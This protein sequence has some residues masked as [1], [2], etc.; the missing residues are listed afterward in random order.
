M[1]RKFVRQLRPT[2]EKYVAPIIKIQSLKESSNAERDAVIKSVEGGNIAEAVYES[3]AFIVA[4]TSGTKTL[5]T[6]KDVQSAMSDNE[7][8]D[9]GKKWIVDFLSKNDNTFL[10]QAIEEIGGDLKKIPNVNWGKVQILHKSIEQYYKNTPKKYAEGAK[11]NTADMVLIT[12]GTV[13]SL[14]K[15]LPN[16]DMSW[17]NDGKVSIDGTD[18]E[19][20]QVS[21]KKGQEAA[22]IGK[23][24]S[25]INQIYGQQAMRPAQLVGEDIQQLEEGLSDIFGKAVGLIKLGATKLLSFTKNMLLKLKNSLLK[26]AIKITK[27]ITKDKAHKSAANISKILGGNLSENFIMEKAPLPPVTINAPLLKEMKILKTEIIAKDLA[28]KEYIQMLK[29]VD[30]IN[31]KKDGAIKVINKGTNPILEM[32]YFKG[33]ANNVLSKKIGDTITR[34]DLNPAL[35][36]V[37]NYASY[38]TFNVILLDMLKNIQSYNTIT[39]SL[40]GLNAKL[41]AEAMFGKTSLPLWIVY[42]MGGGAQYKHTKDEFESSTK[43]DIIKLGE[44]MDVPYMFISIAKSSKN[45]TYNAIYAYILVG[46]VKENDSLQPEYLMLQFINRSGSDWSYKI[47]AS[48]SKV[49]RPD[50]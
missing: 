7:F 36:L 48:S 4:T 29:N 38:R 40:V 17:T 34:E 21:L 1:L 15:A 14:L 8:D 44:S 49:G 22:R 2:Q 41:R 11:K 50:V 47:D 13:D 25:L 42:G 28:N 6:I 26:S 10:L 45:P 9:T 46:S 37:V 19:F 39:D 16:S 20:I 32:N 43:E 3:W 23:L 27:T 31:S 18:I 33:S 35:K 30:A 24:S 5:P 12:K